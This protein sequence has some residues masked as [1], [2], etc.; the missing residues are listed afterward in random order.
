MLSHKF[1][2]F[3]IALIISTV[4]LT[5]SSCG[6]RHGAE[7]VLKLAHGLDPSHSVHIAMEFMGKRI[8]EL[9]GGK[10]KL[11]I[12]PSGQLGSEPQCIELLQLGSLALTKVSSGTLEGFA[13]PFRLFGLPYLFRSKEHLH[14]VLDG[15]IGEQLLLSMEPYLIRGL[16]YYDSGAR[17]FYTTS[18]PIL[19]PEDLTGLKIRVMRSPLTIEMMQRFKGSATPINW[20]E[21]YTALQSGV[22]DG[23]EN[24][25]PSF[26]LS[27]H[28]EVCKHYSL[29]EHT[30]LP[31][32]IVISRRVWEDLSEQEQ[33]WLMAALKES[34]K[35]QR[36]L[37]EVSEKNCLEEAIKSGI[38]IYYPDKAPFIEQVKPMYESFRKF[39]AVY[40]L[41]AKIVNTLPEEEV[42][43]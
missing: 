10:M 8:D 12:Y 5:T 9:S 41:I 1:S 42:T 14:K 43:P 6:S 26:V 40:P 20:G 36:E 27:H 22:V 39:P 38:K 21:L 31:D 19:K 28:H 35:Y 32:I 13:D 33:G 7:R 30:M 17:S 24:N 2:L 16:G 18:K 25:S 37:W 4:S 34:V 15:E 11:D 29:N 3:Y 23:A